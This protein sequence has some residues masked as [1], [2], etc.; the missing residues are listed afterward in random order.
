[1]GGAGQ[2]LWGE[3]AQPCGGAGRL[4]LN[5]MPCW[6]LRALH[7][8]HTAGFLLPTP[9]SLDSSPFYL[10][11]AIKDRIV[12]ALDQLYINGWTGNAFTSAQAARNLID[13]ATGATL[14]ALG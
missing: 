11:S 10:T 4:Q 14:G 5:R 12:E 6:L 2:G 7:K 1:M 3:R 9:I 13:L 8:I